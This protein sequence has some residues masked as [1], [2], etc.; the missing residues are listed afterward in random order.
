MILSIRIHAFSW[1]S[2][3]HVSDWSFSGS[4]ASSLEEQPQEPMSNEQTSPNHQWESEPREHKHLSWMRVAPSQ[5]ND[6]VT[7][8]PTQDMNVEVSAISREQGKGGMNTETQSKDSYGINGPWITPLASGVLIR[9]NEHECGENRDDKVIS[10]A[11]STQQWLL[12]SR[13]IHNTNGHQSNPP[14]MNK[15]WITYSIITCVLITF[16][17][18]KKSTLEKKLTIRRSEQEDEQTQ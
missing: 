8:E 15:P 3:A 10:E 17:C 1:G 12:C 6:S 14:D 11:L 5:E 7:K 13:N 4:S 9:K 2:S 16:V 18:L